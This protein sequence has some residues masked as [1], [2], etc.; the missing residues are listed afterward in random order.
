MKK[1]W[2]L[3]CATLLGVVLLLQVA[4]TPSMVRRL[5]FMPRPLVEELQDPARWRLEAE[6]VWIR[7]SGDRRLHGWWILAREAEGQ[8]SCGV[9]VNLNGNAGN[10][11]SRASLGDSLSRRGH[12][13]LLFDYG[14]Y[15][16]S[17]GYPSEAGLHDDAAA[18]YRFVLE[19]K[20]VPEDRVVLVG[21]SLGTAVVLVAPFTS[22]PEA[23]RAQ[24]RVV[25]RWLFDWQEGRFDS[26]ENVT[27]IRAPILMALGRED[28]LVRRRNARA[29]FAAASEPK[30]WVDV[31]EANHNG[32]FSNR[33]FLNELDQFIR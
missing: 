24:L 19:Q 29:L 18:A 1:V 13:V 14:G 4:T 25:P 7:A 23:A 20:Q 17:E 27:G 30:K 2:I 8:A 21:H 28:A 33:A 3:V 9:V 31:P 15:G 11:A 32:V 16:A 26:V 22:L 10:I 6:E 5:T 12:D